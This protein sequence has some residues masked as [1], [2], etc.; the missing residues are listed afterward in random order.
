MLTKTHHDQ[1]ILVASNK[2]NAMPMN[3][4]RGEALL[5]EV[6]MNYKGYKLLRRY[7]RTEARWLIVGAD[8]WTVAR[9]NRVAEAKKI[10][11][12]MVEE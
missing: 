9:A 10:I 8:G 1:I 11:D 2:V 5:L 3:S 7:D 4:K 6:K 12:K